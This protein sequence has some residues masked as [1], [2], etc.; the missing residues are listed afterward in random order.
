VKSILDNDLR[1][2]GSVL[3]G[4]KISIKNGGAYGNGVYTSKIPLYSQ[5]YAPCEKWNGKYVQTLFM[6]RQPADSVTIYGC[7]GCYTMNMIGRYDIHRLYGGLVG[8]NEVQFVTQDF[9]S[10][11]IQA[12]L[13]KIH[14][15]PPDELGGEYF[16]VSKILDNIPK[17]LK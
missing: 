3:N 4:Q 17:K 7:E 15:C 1:V 9:K 6:V 8:A 2:G 12:I 16:E 5:L 10:I 14:D 11:V 13:V